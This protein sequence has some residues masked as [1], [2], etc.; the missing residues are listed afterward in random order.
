[1]CPFWRITATPTLSAGSALGWMVLTRSSMNQSK[2]V[3]VQLQTFEC[4]LD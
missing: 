1:M 4:D 2:A 3:N